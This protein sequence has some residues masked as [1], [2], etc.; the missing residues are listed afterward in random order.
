MFDGFSLWHLLI[1]FLIIV[2]VFGS[3]KL[4]SLG[5]DLGKALRGFRQAMHGE[6]DAPETG[7]K[8]E[9]TVTKD[10]AGAVDNAKDESAQQHHDPKS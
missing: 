8:P 9:P 6:E 3:K 2:L 10:A 4:V 1:L 5:P 7:H